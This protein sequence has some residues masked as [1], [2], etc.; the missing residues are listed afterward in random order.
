MLNNNFGNLDPNEQNNDKKNL[1]IF[2]IIV[3]A[4]FAVYDLFVKQP[5]VDAMKAKQAQEAEANPQPAI[6][7]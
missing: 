6:A 3:F 2:M 1:V 5:Y 4:L 7:K